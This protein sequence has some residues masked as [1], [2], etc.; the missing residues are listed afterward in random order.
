MLIYLWLLKKVDE[1]YKQEYNL[2]ISCF[3]LMF[4]SFDLEISEL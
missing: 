4:L 1:G 3:P 2:E